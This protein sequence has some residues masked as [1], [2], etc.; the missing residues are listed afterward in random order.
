MRCELLRQEYGESVV[1]RRGETRRFYQVLAPSAVDSTGRRERVELGGAGISEVPGLSDAV[2]HCPLCGDEAGSDPLAQSRHVAVDSRRHA[3]HARNDGFPLLG[4]VGGHEIEY[5]GNPL[6]WG[7][8]VVEIGLVV[9]SLEGLDGEP[10]PVQHGRH[11]HLI[12][13]IQWQGRRQGGHGL[14]FDLG[15][16]CRRLR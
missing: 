5:L 14:P 10:E 6:Q 7:G 3:L 12:S 9:A 1:G 13:L 2:G 15:P 8:D 11:C 4:C 16:R